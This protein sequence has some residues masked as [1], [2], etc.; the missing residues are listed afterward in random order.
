V[1]VGRNSANYKVG[2]IYELQPVPH[3]PTYTHARVGGDM[4]C[5]RAR[6]SGLRTS[7]KM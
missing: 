5:S 3:E 7:A 1:I 6:T 2:R 4:E